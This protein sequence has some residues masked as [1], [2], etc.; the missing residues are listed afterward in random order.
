MTDFSPGPEKFTANTSVSITVKDI[1]KSTA[2]YRDVVG[3]GVE[4]A[5]ERDGRP[6]FVALKAGGVR[7][8]LNQDDGAKGWDRTKGLGFSINFWTTEDID[9]I[10]SRIK[11][12]GGALDS[13]PVDAPWGARFFRLTDP[14]GF[15]LAILKPLA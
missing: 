2:W 12:S 14:D 15:K 7:L 4:R 11:S 8:S 3:F 13:E 5:V 1:Q 9:A 10:A 6:V